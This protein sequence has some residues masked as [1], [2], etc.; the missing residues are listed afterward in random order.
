MGTF[1]E[2]SQ[3]GAEKKRGRTRACELHERKERGSRSGWEARDHESERTNSISVRRETP[4]VVGTAIKGTVNLIFVFPRIDGRRAR[5]R[6]N[7]ASS[8]RLTL[9]RDFTRAP[10]LFRRWVIYR[11]QF[12]IFPFFHFYYFSCCP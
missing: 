11:V 2:L 8:R 3:A 1:T 5:A 10:T 4:S 6:E 12:F 9:R 7:R